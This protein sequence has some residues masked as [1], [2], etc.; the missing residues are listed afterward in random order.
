ML[1]HCKFDLK[2]FADELIRLAFPNSSKGEF[3][4]RLAA[5]NGSIQD[6]W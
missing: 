2:N 5:R 6:Q 1:L 3:L 4:E